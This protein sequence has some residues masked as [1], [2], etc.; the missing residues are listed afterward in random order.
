[1][2]LCLMDHAHMGGDEEGFK[3]KSLEK[4]YRDVKRPCRSDLNGRDLDQ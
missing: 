4:H 3:R 2:A 1:M